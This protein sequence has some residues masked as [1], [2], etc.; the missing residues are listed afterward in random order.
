MSKSKNV[1]Q[2]ILTCCFW[3]ESYDKKNDYLYYNKLSLL[4]FF[5]EINTDQHCNVPVFGF[6]TLLFILTCSP[7]LQYTFV[8]TI[9]LQLSN[10][11]I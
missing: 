11:I 5:S 9:F 2:F 3:Y 8:V 7:H 4:I 10:T 1:K 6:E